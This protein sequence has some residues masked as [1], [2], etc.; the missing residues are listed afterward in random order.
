[1]RHTIFKLGRTKLVL[2]ITVISIFL[3][4]TFDIMIAEVL[5]H[6]LKPKE[7]YLRVAIIALLIAPS[8]SWYLVGLLFELYK[9]EKKLMRLATYDELTGL[10]NRRAFYD[11]CDALHKYS[12]RTKRNY[13]ILS[14]DLDG[15][16]KINDDFGHASGDMVLSSFGKI[17]NDL[18]RESDIVARFGGEEFIFFLPD[19]NLIEAQEF[20]KRLCKKIQMTDVIIDNNAIKYTVSIGIATNECIEDVALEELLKYSDKALYRAKNNGRNQIVMY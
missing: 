17:S 18:S 5:G 19:T 1:M 8:I 13:S 9:L 3:A 11:S 2:A 15:F 20:A 14:V 10:F 16:K 7:D 12:I 4:V 6:N